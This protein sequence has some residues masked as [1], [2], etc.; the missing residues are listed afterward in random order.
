MS[1]IK[2]LQTT[3]DT[4]PSLIEASIEATEMNDKRL[5]RHKEEAEDAIMEVR[6]ANA[7]VFNAENWSEAIKRIKSKYG[8]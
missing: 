6:L 4:L 3:V 1:E 5:A 2:I 8:W 7:A